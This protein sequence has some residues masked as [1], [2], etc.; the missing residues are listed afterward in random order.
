MT[1]GELLDQVIRHHLGRSNFGLD[2]SE[3]YWARFLLDADLNDTVT[4]GLS[5]D[6]I[7]IEE[8]LRAVRDVSR[9]IDNL[10]HATRRFK[11][12]AHAA[13]IIREKI[14]GRNRDVFEEATVALSNLENWLDGVREHATF[15]RQATKK[16]NWRA[17]SVVQA[18]R[19]L[20]AAAKWEEDGRPLPQSYSVLARWPF[21]A[22][23]EPSPENEALRKAYH[24][25]L[26]TFSPTTAKTAEPGPFGRFVEGIFLALG[27]L[28]KDGAA[29]PAASALRSL[30]DARLQED[31][32]Q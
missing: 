17:A 3:H 15:K 32:N 7:S 30:A 31:G 10:S 16:R 23:E 24:D 22:I 26:L 28:G 2:Q 14:E 29:F 5:H 1:M 25:F 4:F 19:I 27:I 9:R 13:W 12:K 8:L 18:C 6:T 11:P 20:W 21:G